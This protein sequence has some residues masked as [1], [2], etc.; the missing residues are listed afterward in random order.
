MTS[1]ICLKSV[2]HACL[3]LPSLMAQRQRACPCICTPTCHALCACR[4][5]NEAAA[6]AAGLVL[7]KLLSTAGQLLENVNAV[8]DTLEE[9]AIY[10]TPT[11]AGTSCDSD[12]SNSRLCV[13]LVRSCL[14]IQMM[15]QADL[16]FHHCFFPKFLLASP[17]Q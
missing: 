15:H 2:Q 16:P 3:R 1:D 11:Q 7:A 4:Y 10:F 8:Y 5:G 17:A 13:D 9:T 6:P 12:S 14:F